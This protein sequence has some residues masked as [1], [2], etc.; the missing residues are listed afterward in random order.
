MIVFVSHDS[1]KAYLNVNTIELTY[2]YTAHNSG[3]GSGIRKSQLYNARGKKLAEIPV[4]SKGSLHSP[5][6]SLSSIQLSQSG[7]SLNKDLPPPPAC[8]AAN[9]ANKS[10]KQLNTSPNRKGYPPPPPPLKQYSPNPPV[11]SISGDAILQKHR[12]VD[13]PDSLPQPHQ[14]PPPI[15][16]IIAIP[17]TPAKSAPSFFQ[18]FFQR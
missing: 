5:S 18:R 10:R 17:A 14:P 4:T 11:Q 3:Y 7:V 2:L 6:N 15:T 8:D 12:S 16:P 9:K 1:L 13:V